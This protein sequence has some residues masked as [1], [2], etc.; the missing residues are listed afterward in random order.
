MSVITQIRRSNED[1]AQPKPGSLVVCAGT[2]TCG[3][4]LS[5]G[6]G[7]LAFKATFPGSSWW[8]HLQEKLITPRRLKDNLSIDKD[9]RKTIKIPSYLS[10]IAKNGTLIGSVA[11]VPYLRQ[12]NPILL[13]NEIS[14]REQYK[15]AVRGAVKEAQQLGRP[16][17]IQPLGIGVY[18]W[19]PELAATLFYEVFQELDIEGRKDIKNKIDITIPIYDVSKKDSPDSKFM[20]RI[21]HLIKNSP[22]A[23]THAASIPDEK[24]YI[25]LSALL[26]KDQ[27]GKELTDFFFFRKR[28][29]T[30]KNYWVKNPNEKMSDINAVLTIISEDLM[31]Q[32]YSEG[33]FGDL[34]Q[35][36]KSAF[37]QNHGTA[38]GL[39]QKEYQRQY[40]TYIKEFGTDKFKEAASNFTPEEFEI[41][42]LSAYMHR[43]GR[44]NEQPFSGDKLYGPRSQEIF[45]A[46]A[47]QLG[48]KAELITFVAGTMSTFRSK[49]EIAGQNKG[50]S[51]FDP[52]NFSNAFVDVPQGSARQK[53]ILME[54]LIEAGHQ[55]DLTRCYGYNQF[56][57]TS[58]NIASRLNGLLTPEISSITVANNFL[59]LSESLCKATGAQVTMVPQDRCC[60]INIG[61]AISSANAPIQTRD[62]LA[63]AGD[64]FSRETLKKRKAPATTSGTVLPTKTASAS[65]SHSPSKDFQLGNGHKVTGINDKGRYYEVIGKNN[66]NEARSIRVYKE[67]A[68]KSFDGSDKIEGYVGKKMEENVTFIFK[69]FKIE[70]PSTKTPV[71]ASTATTSALPEKTATTTPPVKTATTALPATTSDT[72]PPVK[73][74]PPA[75]TAETTLPAN[76][77]PRAESPSSQEESSALFSMMLNYAEACQPILLGLIVGSIILAALSLVGMPLAVALSVGVGAG[78]LTSGVSFFSSPV[79]E[80]ILEENNDEKISKSL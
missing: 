36:G 35:K 32:Q 76:T 27:R 44:T 29:A 80:T 14:A 31:E 49:T 41:M 42:Q 30:H 61:L 56:S 55:T 6:A 43:I 66:A 68:I 16:L 20:T 79:K 46:V 22:V 17:Y 19:D 5:M 3:D 9:I 65:P 13:N 24:E 45:T 54:R 11:T 23:K 78:I 50:D 62:R 18:G 63:A 2:V 53:A 74:A 12:N 37:H 28:L 57:S 34:H 75:R 59:Y 10:N 26:N 77:S 73:T 72:A 4:V 8:N 51:T 58:Q 67:G 64:L 15:D 70:L 1:F 39:R 7:F 21:N 60:S 48:F 69:H 52:K 71:T 47:T 33:N 38:H 25:K 40:L